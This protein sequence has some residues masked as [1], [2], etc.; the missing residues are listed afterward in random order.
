MAV[1]NRLTIISPGGNLA[2][3]WRSWFTYGHPALEITVG[4][5]DSSYDICGL[6]LPGTSGISARCS[7]TGCFQVAE[8]IDGYR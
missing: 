2:A 3:I 4:R 6:V 7:I 1:T 5:A 8:Q